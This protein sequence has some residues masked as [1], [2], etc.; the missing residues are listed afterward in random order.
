MGGLGLAPGIAAIG[1]LS[2]GL[3][4]DGAGALAGKNKNNPLKATKGAMK[5]LAGAAGITA[6]IAASAGLV[7]AAP[8][9]VASA[10]LI[11]YAPAI[12]R[13]GIAIA[14]DLM[15][16]SP[17]VYDTAK[18]FGKY[19]LDTV[20]SYPDDVYENT[21][22]ERERLAERV[23]RSRERREEDQRRAREKAKAKA[24]DEAAAKADVRAREQA[25]RRAIAQAAK[26]RNA[27]GD[28][29][30]DSL[31]GS[32]GNKGGSVMS[33]PPNPW[34]DD[35]RDS[36]DGTNGNRGQSVAF[37]SGSWGDDGRDSLDGTNGNRSEERRG[38]KEC[39]L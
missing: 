36:L 25:D 18:F 37:S 12:N 20:K 28:D 4:A 29:E 16:G 24:E 27:W 17:G 3:M 33:R 39:R 13:G 31:D 34:G 11:Q 7:E 9:I 15:D 21:K 5:G 2:A 30:E 38:G 10:P 6:G 8:A 22:H 14:N 32:N 26:N 1:T 35:G 23:T 19:A